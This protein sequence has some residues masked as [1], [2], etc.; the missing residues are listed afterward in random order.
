M[1]VFL[2]IAVIAVGL[3][4]VLGQY[5]HQKC[6]MSACCVNGGQYQCN[7]GT[8]TCFMGQ[9]VKSGPRCGPGNN[10][11]VCAKPE[12]DGWLNNLDEA[13]EDQSVG[14]SYWANRW[15][16]NLDEAEDEVVMPWQRR[17]S[18]S[19]CRMRCRHRD[20]GREFCMTMCMRDTPRRL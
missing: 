12:A 18:W 4:Q 6:C 20:F 14:D 13:E 5:N 1:K 7:M 19:D 11:V 2:C 17:N 10:G 3:T 9:Q 8:F 15:L 16:N